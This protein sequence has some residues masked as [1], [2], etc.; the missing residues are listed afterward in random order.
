MKSHSSGQL[1]GSI[2][3]PC[4]SQNTTK[5]TQENGSYFNDIDLW[6]I[7]RPMTTVHDLSYS[8][9]QRWS[10]PS[11]HCSQHKTDTP[12]EKKMVLFLT[13]PLSSDLWHDPPSVLILLG[14][15]GATLSD[16]VESVEWLLLVTT[17]GFVGWLLPL[18]WLVFPLWLLCLTWWLLSSVET[19]SNEWK[20]IN[21]I[22]N[23]QVVN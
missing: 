9:H 15:F 23:L 7:Y 12:N 14:S 4:S 8:Y 1:F 17:E 21:N 19:L 16:T 10:N 2:V 3:G 6:P 22:G 18:V 13:N 11:K 20:G 5:H